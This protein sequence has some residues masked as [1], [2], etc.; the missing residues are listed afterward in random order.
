MKKYSL[1][2]HTYLCKHALGSSKDMIEQGI[3]EGFEVFGISDHI[4]YPTKCTSFR[5]E[6]EQKT[7]YLNDL[8]NLKSKYKN[9]KVLRGFE[10]E[11]QRDLLYQLVDMFKNDEID[12]LILGQHYQNVHKE[13]TYY[14]MISDPSLIKNYVDQCIEAMK[15]GLILFIAHPDLFINNISKFC[16]TCIDESKRLIEAA[17]KYDVYLEYNAG[18]MR[19]SINAGFSQEEYRYPRYEFWQLVKELNAKVV[20]S[21]DAH[22]PQ[23]I[24]DDIYQLACQQVDELGLNVIEE[25]NFELYQERVNEFIKRYDEIRING[26]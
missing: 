26:L 5:M 10:A 6:F 23:Q 25:I 12:Y 22:T 9:I 8:K 1:H 11:Y 4:A 14:G 15:T 20:V 16:D 24:N 21:S 19:S 7:D 3:K 13:N 18:G 2:N 17:I